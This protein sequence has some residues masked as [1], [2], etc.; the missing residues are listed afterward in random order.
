MGSYVFQTGSVTW[1]LGF[2]FLMKRLFLS[3][4]RVRV[5]EGDGDL[6]K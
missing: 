4:N 1:F 2:V 6:Q 3:R 5:P